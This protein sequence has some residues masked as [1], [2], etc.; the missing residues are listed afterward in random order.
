MTNIALK[1]VVFKSKHMH[2]E[3]YN[4]RWKERTIFLQIF[5]PCPTCFNGPKFLECMFVFPI[6]R[7]VKFVCLLEKMLT[8]NIKWCTLRNFH[9]IKMFH[10]WIDTIKFE[11]KMSWHLTWREIE[12]NRNRHVSFDCFAATVFY[13]I[14]FEG[15]KKI[16]SLIETTQRMWEMV[17]RW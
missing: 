6:L 2:C 13:W 7:F 10:M 8:S 16:E 15:L 5:S 4:S 3:K 11:I 12:G 9:N 14:L 1:T 17:K